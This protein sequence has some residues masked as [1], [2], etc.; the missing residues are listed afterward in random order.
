MPLHRD[1]PRPS[2]RRTFL[3]HGEKYKVRQQ[4]N[5]LLLMALGLER[6][7]CIL[8]RSSSS[9]EDIMRIKRIRERISLLLLMV[10][11]H[12]E[13]LNLGYQ[14]S[15]SGGSL[16]SHS[17]FTEVEFVEEFR[18]R[19]HHFFEML[20]ALKDEHG[21]PMANDGIPII[22]EFGKQGHRSHVSAD[23]AL[24]ILLRKL[25]V[26]SR[27]LDIRRVMGGSRT[28]LSDIYNYMLS[29]LYARY[30]GVVSNAIV[31]K[32]DFPLFHSM[33][34]P[35]DNIVMFLDGHFD[36]TCRPGGEGC[37]NMNLN[38]YETFAGKERL[39]G[40][41]YQ[42]A[43]LPNGMALCWGPWLGT[44]HDATMLMQSGLLEQ[45]SAASDQLG[46]QYCAFSDSAYPASCFIEKIQKPVPGGQLSRLQRQYNA[47]MS[48]FRIVIENTFGEATNYFS[49]VRD[50]YNKKMGS[51]QVG[52]MFPI[53][54]FFY[55]LH[56]IFYGNQITAYMESEAF[57]SPITVAAYLAKADDDHA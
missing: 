46:R 7:R 12:N 32:D 48:R 29:V 6:Q 35:H 36:P 57:V 2:V 56:T 42:G 49:A 54:M 30:R 52:K 27:W 25:G 23:K 13:S 31:W 16:K 3:Y 8:W 24:M 37:V 19:K 26:S 34:C 14:R 17:D 44:V 5:I 40:L 10:Y 33:G 51:Q 45:L 39:H 4:I 47:L 38:D 22:L 18:F 9:F 21:R 11:K 50:R 55:N 1:T 53:V 15:L 41:K 28:Y 20:H 43:I